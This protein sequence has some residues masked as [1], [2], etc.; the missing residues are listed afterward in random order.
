M[1][2]RIIE[3]F[4]KISEGVRKPTRNKNTRY[5]EN[6]IISISIAARLFGN[7]KIKNRLIV[8]FLILSIIPLLITGTI[9]Y[10]QSK[11]SLETNIK[12][13]SNVLVEQLAKICEVEVSKIEISTREIFSSDTM[14]NNL[15]EFSNMVE[16]AKFD[17][18]NNVTSFINSKLM[19]YDKLF[20][21]AYLLPDGSELMATQDASSTLEKEAI[22]KELSQGA[23]D[24]KGLMFTKLMTVSKDGKK[25]IAI[26]RAIKSVKSGADIGTLIVIFKPEQ[27][28]SIFEK[29]NL[30]DKTKLYIVSKDGSVICSQSSN[31]SVETLSNPEI[32]KRLS[33]GVQGW[34]DTIGK[35]LVTASKVKGTDWYL[36]CTVENSYIQKDSNRILVSIIIVAVICLLAAIALSLLIT[37]SISYPLKNMIDVMVKAKDGDLSVKAEEAGNNEISEV[38]KNFNTMVGNIGNLVSMIR[39][40]VESVIGNSEVIAASAEKSNHYSQNVAMSVNHIAT[41]SS[42]QAGDI[43]ESVEFFNGLS[44]EI[45]GVV[46]DID[47]A[48]G[49]VDKTR[50]LSQGALDTV[51]E[52]NGKAQE[53]SEVTSKIITD[54]VGLNTEMKEIEKITK[55]IVD[56]AEQ[57]NLLSLNA[58]IEAARAGGAGKGFAV[59][60]EEVRKLAEQ[61]KN[62]SISIKNTINK[63]RYKVETT[64]MEANNASNIIT[65]QM[66]AVDKTDAAFNMIFTSMESLTGQVKS[67]EK[68]IKNI[69]EIKSKALSSMENIS[70][71]S[72]ETAAATE[73]V[74]SSTMEQAETSERLAGLAKEMNKLAHE[75]SY[76]V[77]IFKV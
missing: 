58:A 2:K 22:F 28:S 71:V 52:L 68:S 76:A 73:E 13:Y 70:A 66:D 43:S 45:D 64:A 29:V 26:S 8:S 57:T 35:E 3:H 34:T 41:G 65:L 39:G 36:A 32:K 53:T 30:G 67:I 31:R 62:S 46:K 15:P 33:E 14:Q 11:D 61:S 75:L 27:F 5:T 1:L 25:G 54:I 37:S 55:A 12:T 50:K 16:S 60:A 40:T 48:S 51:R 20:F 42:E 44:E 10:S 47:I 9:S 4:K 56:I 21:Q 49:V 18:T 17:F 7:T 72:E 74:S 19:V 77:E 6:N 59:V 69:T 38:T 23:K 24:A 63:I